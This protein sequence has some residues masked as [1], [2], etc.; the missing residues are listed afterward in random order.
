ME[1]DGEV[2]GD[3][4]GGIVFQDGHKYNVAREGPCAK[5]YV[6]LLNPGVFST[7]IK[8]HSSTR[9]DAFNRAHVGVKQTL[10]TNR[11]EVRASSDENSR[12]RFEL[13]DSSAA[14]NRG[15][16]YLVK[17]REKCIQKT[18]KALDAA[19]PITDQIVS[20]VVMDNWDV[21]PDKICAKLRLAG[22]YCFSEDDI[23]ARDEAAGIHICG[24]W[25]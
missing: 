24:R 15:H 2:E 23:R 19:G 10:C 1:V 7:L 22:Y 21:V 14:Y 5:L 11:D 13:D 25:E 6:T 12:F 9:A 16:E 20:S 17:E 3:F 4:V 8:S 18:L